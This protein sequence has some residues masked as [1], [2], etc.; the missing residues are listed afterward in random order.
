MSDFDKQ[1]KDF[2]LWLK[3]KNII[4]SDKVKLHDFRESNQGR[5]L[6]AL[7]DIEKDETLFT[8]PKNQ[9]FSVDRLNDKDLEPLIAD[10]DPWLALITCMMCK[11]NDPAWTPY[12]S[13]LPTASQFHT[14]MFW[15]QDEL[16]LLQG[17]AV[18]DRIGKSQADAAYNDHVKPVVDK[19]IKS[20]PNL[21]IPNTLESFHRMGS[22]IMA[23]SFDLAKPDTDNDDDDDEEEEEEE[24]TKALV[25]PADMLNAHTRLCNSHLYDEATSENLEMK[26]I[27][28][29]KAGDQIY[30]TYGEL[31]NSDLL[32]RYGYAQV[33]G[34]QFDVVEVPT[35]LFIDAITESSSP[36]ERARIPQAIEQLQDLAEDFYDDSFEI[37]ISG[38]PDPELLAIVSCLYVAIR[39]PDVS[40]STILEKTFRHAENG[41]MPESTTQVWHTA[42]EKR[43]Q[44]YP[45]DLVDE[46][47]HSTVPAQSD[48]V[49]T[50][51]A[52]MA[53]EVLLGEIRILLKCIDWSSGSANV[54]ISTLVVTKRKRDN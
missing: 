49:L 16:K 6:I 33:G 11:V 52:E 8:I 12:F 5:G 28:S 30:N 34:T 21:D 45:Q 7:H 15:S 17:S 24:T 13:L 23:Y 46:A 36:E 32:R 42:L 43:L 31:P 44:D 27:K 10:L 4:L 51:R 48:Q 19:Y 53:R 2:E 22:I 9:V 37:S 29:I 54:P 18:V 40:L 35:S 47:K 50:T 39:N 38:E 26:A 41:A 20:H 14:P 3:A 1:T 25:P